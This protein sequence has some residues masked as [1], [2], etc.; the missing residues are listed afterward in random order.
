MFKN[1]AG[2]GKEKPLLSVCCHNIRPGNQPD[3]C[4]V[5]CHGCL[6]GNAGPGSDW[7][8]GDPVSGNRLGIHE[9]AIRFRLSVYPEPAMSDARLYFGI[10]VTGEFR[11]LDDTSYTS[12][13][14]VRFFKM[15]G[16]M[17]EYSR[18]QFLTYDVVSW[19]I[20]GSG[21]RWISKKICCTYAE[22]LAKSAAD[23]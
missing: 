10:P 17:A 22:S 8:S 12:H 7:L 23:S 2:H 20:T 19:D 1:P 21:I 14:D 18:S 3:P 11:T 4:K 16:E 5:R 13:A 9:A 15:G 6:S